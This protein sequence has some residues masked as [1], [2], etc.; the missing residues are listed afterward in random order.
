MLF[1]CFI[2]MAYLI[3]LSA[4]DVFQ[5]TVFAKLTHC[6][7]ALQASSVWAWPPAWFRFCTAADHNRLNSFLHRC[8][9]L[10][11]WSSNNYSTPF[12]STIAE[13][14][15][16]TLF[17]EITHYRYHFLQSYLPNRPDIDYN[18]RERHHKKTLILKTAD[19]NKRDFLI[20]NLHCGP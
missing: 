14:I 2:V 5:A 20:R 16:D 19:L 4:K 17:K 9:K 3:E 18:L 15:E 7:P 6:L 10:G 1:V 11:F 12:L 8:V 13:H